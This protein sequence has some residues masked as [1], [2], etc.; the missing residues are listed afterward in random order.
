MVVRV[1]CT[2]LLTRL[3]DVIDVE[4]GI[5]RSCQT[6]SSQ[7]AHECAQNWDAEDQIVLAEFV[8]NFDHNSMS[9]CDQLIFI[10][11]V[12][13]ARVL[14]ERIDPPIPNHDTAYLEF[15]LSIVVQVVGNRRY[16]VTGV[17]LSG[18]D[19]LAVAEL[20]VRD[21]E[22]AHELVE[23]LGNL[24]LINSGGKYAAG[25]LKTSADWLIKE[26]NVRVIVP[27]VL[28]VGEVAPVLDRVCV[29]SEPVRAYLGPSTD[30]ARATGASLQPNY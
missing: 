19:D 29:I 7:L 8:E 22:I 18:Q 17:A 27:G 13:V 25:R 14:V 6:D 26:E 20:R 30:H 10:S 16:E 2:K 1:A 4:G 21:E 12:R 11:E 3:P 24:L 15:N 5:A 23:V 9:S 28:V